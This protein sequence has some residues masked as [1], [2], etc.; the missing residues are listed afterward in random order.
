MQFCHGTRYNVETSAAEASTNNTIQHRTQ[1]QIGGASR[2]GGM[3]PSTIYLFARA[4]QR[5]SAVRK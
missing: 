5:P 4:E 3:R 1:T 2:V